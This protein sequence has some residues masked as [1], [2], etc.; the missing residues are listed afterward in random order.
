MLSYKL[1]DLVADE[2]SQVEAELFHGLNSGIHVIDDVGN[3]IL[4]S[5]GKR[6]R[7][8]IALLVS[9]F[10]NYQGR[11]HIDLACALEYLH[12]ATLLHDDV[13]DN[14]RVRRGSSTAN[15]VWGDKTSILVGDFL[16]SYSFSLLVKIGILNILKIFSETTSQMAKG[17]TFEL[18][19]LG[20]LDLSE[21]DYF[22]IITD[23]TASLFSA[24]C[25]C[26]AILGEAQQEVQHALRSYGLNLGIAFQ[27]TDDLLD[28]VASVEEF[29][30]SIGKDLKEKKITLPLIYTLQ[31]LSGDKKSTVLATLQNEMLSEDEVTRIIGLVKETGGI[32]YTRKQARLYSGQAREVLRPIPSSPEK[33]ALL[34]AA[35]YVVERKS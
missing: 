34:E 30:K 4:K 26:S 29:G 35:D 22:S 28:Y 18:N 31:N 1:F 3:H 7:P 10:F 23:K 20:N 16:F 19:H 8:L 17:E 9:R 21:E 27:L 5:G 12:T 14:G 6:F 25:E 32:N 24:A 33:T 2:L 15:S 11:H 13:V